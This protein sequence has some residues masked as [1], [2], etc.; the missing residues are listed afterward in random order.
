VTGPKPEDVFARHH[1]DVYRY[2]VHMTGSR[3]AADDLQQEVFLPVVRALRNG[4][5]IG[6]ERGWV[7]SIARNL[8]ELPISGG[9][10]TITPAP[11]L[12]PNARPG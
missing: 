7:F 4:G 8:L 9:W 5:P 2:L 6:H 10:C 1:R 3:D 11:P 12:P